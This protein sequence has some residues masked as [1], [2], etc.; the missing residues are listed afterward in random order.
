M[1]VIGARKRIDLLSLYW[2]YVS[3]GALYNILPYLNAIYGIEFFSL[4]YD[5]NT[6][7]LQLF[8]T[9]TCNFAFS[10]AYINHYKNVPYLNRAEYLR[11]SGFFYILGATFIFIPTIYLANTYGWHKFTN[12]GMGG[13]IFYTLTA[14]LKYFLVA[15]YL[16]YLYEYRFS[17]WTLY[18]M[19]MHTI[20]AAVDGARTTYLPLIFITFI[21]WRSSVKYQKNLNKRMLAYI[22]FGIVFSIMVRA[23]IMGDQDNF[24]SNMGFSVIIEAIAG[25]YMSLQT[26]YLINRDLPGYY[27]LGSNYLFDLF[28]WFA[29]QGE[30]RD[31]IS[32]FQSWIDKSDLY[33]VEKYAPMGGFFYIAEAMASFS[34]V[35]PFFITYIYAFISSQVEARKNSNRLIYLSYY[36][37]IGFLFTKAI[38]GNIF[39]L[40][41][42]QLIFLGVMIFFHKYLRLIR[43]FSSR[44][45]NMVIQNG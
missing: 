21:C 39:K 2:V 13:G 36:V 31:S 24:V 42:I 8:L 26:I 28:A 40:F 35:G 27:L 22:F 37:T 16:Y 5:L 19:A 45:R 4:S 7:E 18:F 29:P 1:C 14:Y 38:F 6:I 15:M 41:V 44:H 32:F 23:S 30:I 12:D 17:S 20:L 11:N 34:Y 43:I 33:L 9:A 3:F 25:S 10:F